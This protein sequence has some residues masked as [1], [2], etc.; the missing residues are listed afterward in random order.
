MIYRKDQ[1][2]RVYRQVLTKNELYYSDI[3]GNVN[4]K[5]K[6]C[7]SCGQYV[8]LNNFY[9]DSRRPN[10]TRN[11]CILCWEEKNGKTRLDEPPQIVNDLFGGTYTIERV[12]R[13]VRNTIDETDESHLS[14]EPFFFV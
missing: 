9:L 7:P 8:D 4:R 14:L 2:A 10:A 13:K 5:H 6:W 1:I 11:Q 3:Y 12:P